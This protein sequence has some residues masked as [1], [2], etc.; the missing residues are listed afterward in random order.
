MRWI[1]LEYCAWAS[2]IYMFSYHICLELETNISSSM[3][4][5]KETQ[6]SYD[7]VRHPRRTHE[8]YSTGL[9]TQ[10]RQAGLC[11]TG[12]VFVAEFV[13]FVEPVLVRA[14]PL[15]TGVVTLVGFLVAGT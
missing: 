3:K 1:A 6:A 15:F 8:P 2:L 9:L 13:D 4:A 7:T 14:F 10:C 11:A 5:F 12:S